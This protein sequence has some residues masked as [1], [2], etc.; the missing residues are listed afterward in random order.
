MTRRTAIAGLIGGLCGGQDVLF[1]CP[2]D[3]DVRSGKPDKCPKCGMRLVAGIPEPAE[4][5]VKIDLAPRAIRPG[6]PVGMRFRVTD[7]KTG[8]AVT[9]FD[10]VHEK[11]F[12]LFLVSQDL[13]FFAHEHPE[14]QPDGSF[15]F[16]GT[17]PKSGEYRVLCDFYPAGATP[18]MI[19]KTI[20]V[21]GRAP[22][23]RLTENA[24]PK[25]AEN[26]RV[27]MSMQPAQP[28]SG[29]KTMLFFQLDPADGLEPYLG[30]W[31]HML[32]ASSDL[33]DMLHA[34]PAWQEGGPKIQFN[35]IFPRPGLHRLWVQ[36]QRRGV[37]NTAAFTVPVSSL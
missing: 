26:L 14:A 22:R 6:V 5:S 27:S 29:N 32:A 9:R 16:R 8:T 3:P 15:T 4:Y 30:A 24:A 7:P 12:H 19:A 28:L 36:F 2:M 13:E 33:V 31:G 23:A 10:V 17:L 25:K 1:V 20:I 18:Q 34:H 35:I 11:L 21:P 37:V